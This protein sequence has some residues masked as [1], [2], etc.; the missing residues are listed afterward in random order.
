M[1]NARALVKRATYVNEYH[2]LTRKKAR[3]LFRTRYGKICFLPAFILLAVAA[4]A[5]YFGP[6]G[7]TGRPDP[8]IIQ[9]APK[10]DYF[11]LWLYAFALPTCR[12]RWR[13]QRSSLAR[14][15]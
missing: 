15:S 12:L 11:F 6:F 13:R 10:P 3:R 1:A 8:T 7:P 4:C 9:T 14:L 5:L 2:E